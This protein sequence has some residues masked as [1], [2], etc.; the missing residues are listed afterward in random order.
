M[1]LWFYNRHIPLMHSRDS[2][3]CV[4]PK[5]LTLLTKKTVETAIGMKARQK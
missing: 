3:V 2:K 5:P 1:M 4:T